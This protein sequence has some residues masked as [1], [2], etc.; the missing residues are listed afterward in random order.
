MSGPIEF[1]VGSGPTVQHFQVIFTSGG[2]YAWRSVGTGDPEPFEYVTPGPDPDLMIGSRS[3][4]ASRE[5]ATPHNV[6]E[7][8]VLIDWMDPSLNCPSV[9]GISSTDAVDWGEVLP[10]WTRFVHRK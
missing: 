6:H 4:G 5:S 10:Q 9:S 8:C 1:D 7:L 3:F 2:M